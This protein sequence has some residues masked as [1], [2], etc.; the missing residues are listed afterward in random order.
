MTPKEKEKYDQVVNSVE[1]LKDTFATFQK[2]VDK[3]GG[4]V[5]TLIEKVHDV[6]KD[7]EQQV[8][9]QTK[10]IEEWDRRLWGLVAVLVGAL[11]SLAAGLIVALA[12]K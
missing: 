11:L 3:L 10:R 8:A 4:K 9:D 7:V 1:I 2:E 12:R 5:E 6:T